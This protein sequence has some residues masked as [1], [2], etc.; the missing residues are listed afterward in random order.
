MQNEPLVINLFAGPGAGKSTLAAGLFFKLKMAGVNCELVTEY[1][2]DITWA[3][4]NQHTF[5]D[6]IF[7][8]GKQHH[9]QHRL[10]NGVDVMITDSPL[11]LSAHY[12]N[13]KSSNLKSTFAT[14]V[15]QAFSQF[16][17]INFFVERA[18]A[19]NPK[20]RSQ[21]YEEAQEIDLSVQRI[22]NFYGVPFYPVIGDEVG[23][24]EI[25]D[26]VS[27]EL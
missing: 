27:K 21:T 3:G 22:L 1:A 12:A 14:L 11:M 5:D 25:F 7:I 16:N 17:N 26:V 24:Q 2:K 13:F 4:A 8:F 15:Y 10:L 18:K 20:G 23:L 19:Y 9:R 6:Q